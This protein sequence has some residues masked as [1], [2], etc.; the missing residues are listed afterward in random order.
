MSTESTYKK[1]VLI[2]GANGGIGFELA[3]LLAEKGHKVYIGARNTDAGQEAEKRLRDE[4]RL[5][6]KFVQLDVTDSESIKAAKDLIE[7]AENRLDVLVNNAGRLQYSTVAMTMKLTYN[8]TATY[9]PP[10]NLSETDLQDYIRVMNTNFFGL[11]NCTNTFLPLI[12]KSPP[13][14][15]AIVNVSSSLGSN[16]ALAAREIPEQFSKSG[17]YSASKAAANSYAIGLAN[18]LRGERIR[19]NCVGPGLVKTKMNNYAEGG[20]TVREGTELL[21]PWVLLGPEDDDKTCQFYN[22]GAPKAW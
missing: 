17:P 7:K 12:R 3:R 8:V 18:E 4:Y 6:A 22:N 20:K 11:V 16:S 14:Y 1:V 21:V 9:H 19:V 15:G 13:G 10:R 2:T 5:D